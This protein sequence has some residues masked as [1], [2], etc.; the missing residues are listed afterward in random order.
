MSDTALEHT[1]VLLPQV[2][3]ALNIQASGVY[4]DT[5]FGRGGHAGA[6]LEKL[7]ADGRLVC[8]DRD[9]VAGRTA[10]APRL[11]EGAMGERIGRAKAAAARYGV[12]MMM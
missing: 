3:A 1:P 8:L 7:V 2:L 5:T 12:D 11:D 10:P 6:I 4:L 9:P